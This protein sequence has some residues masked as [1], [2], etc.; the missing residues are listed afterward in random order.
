MIKGSLSP[1]MEFN[2]FISKWTG[3]GLY[4]DQAN[5]SEGILVHLHRQPQVLDITVFMTRAYIQI[6][7]Y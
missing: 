2:F 3:P 7:R 1:F 5:A 4:P 6:I